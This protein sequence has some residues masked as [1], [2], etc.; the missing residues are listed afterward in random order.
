MT[1]CN[2]FKVVHHI[3]KCFEGNLSA[4]K[5]VLLLEI[6]CKQED[7]AAQSSPVQCASE[8]DFQAAYDLYADR[9][10]RIRK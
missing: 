2:T 3:T 8:I 7:Y 9:L 5:S 6:S 10:I 1:L 4:M